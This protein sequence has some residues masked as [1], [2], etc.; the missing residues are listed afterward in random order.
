MVILSSLLIISVKMRSS[1][2]ALSFLLPATSLAV[3]PVVDLSYTSYRGTSLPNGITQWL[4]VRYTPPPLGDL[5]FREPHDPLPQR[6]VIDADAFGPFCLGTDQGPPTDEMSEDCLFL[7]V[8]APSVAT[9]TSKLPVYVFIQGGGFNSNSKANNGSGLV[10]AS[11][12]NIVV[13]NFSYRTFA[14]SLLKLD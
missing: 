8:F 14:P 1:A 7:N 6:A 11:G 4:G 9:K 2:L 10:M 3:S 13:V 5:R 12:M